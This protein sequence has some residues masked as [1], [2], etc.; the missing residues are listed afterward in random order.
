MGYFEALIIAIIEGLTE[1]LPISSTGHMIIA[2]SILGVHLD[3]KFVKLFIVCI[4]LGA[5]LSVVVFYFKR[6]FKSIIFYQKLFLAFLP[7]AVIGLLLKKHIDKAFENVL[8]I[9]LFLFIGGIILLFIDKWF[10]NNNLDKEE[11]IT[12]QKAFKI[13]SASGSAASRKHRASGRSTS[14]TRSARRW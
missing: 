3:D 12:F 6:F 5:I 7:V 1:F 10:V 11:D 8:G 13:T 14:S 2:S 9:A 4:Q